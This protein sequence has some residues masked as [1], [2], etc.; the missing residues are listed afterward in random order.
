MMRKFRFFWPW[1]EE[2]EERWLQQ[3]SQAG[4]HLVSVSLPCSYTFAQ[5]EPREYAYRLDFTSAKRAD[6]PA[7]YQL[8]ADAGWEHI[9]VLGSWQ[10][11]RK[12]AAP[13]EEP[14][15]FTDVESKIAMYRRVLGFSA[16]LL[17]VLVVI[18]PTPGRLIQLM[19]GWRGWF[20]VIVF[21][22]YVVLIALYIVICVR[23]WRRMNQLKR[24]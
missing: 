8:F 14:E 4:W 18:A 10:Y 9:G 16:L 22:V 24:P 15:I 19:P 5:G 21:A 3:M 12:L 6:L 17:I 1:Q 20:G 7:Y 11:F 13:D 2:Q 23:L